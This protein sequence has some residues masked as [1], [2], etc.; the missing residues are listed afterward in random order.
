MNDEKGIT[1][2]VKRQGDWPRQTLPC[3]QREKQSDLPAECDL[4]KPQ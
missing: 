4:K 3:N 2:F 1:Y